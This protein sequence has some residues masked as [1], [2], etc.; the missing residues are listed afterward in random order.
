[1]R[2]E[3]ELAM[4]HG[5]ESPVWDTIEDTHKC[6]NSNLQLLVENSKENDMIF[7][8][9]HNVDTVEMAKKFILEK[10]IKD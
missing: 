7:V 8:A 1:M 10:G 9:S 6:Y 4:K 3:R 2:E 5:Y